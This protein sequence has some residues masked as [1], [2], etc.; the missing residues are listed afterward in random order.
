MDLPEDLRRKELELCRWFAGEMTGDDRWG[1]IR[2]SRSYEDF[3][4]RVDAERMQR[5]R[6]GEAAAVISKRLEVLKA[7]EPV[8]RKTKRHRLH[9][10][11]GFLLRKLHA[12]GLTPVM[13]SRYLMRYHRVEISPRY[14]SSILRELCL[15]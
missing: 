14:L 12:E 8:R 4:F 3:L 2:D 1:H 6:N 9:N 11:Y 10:E 7:N 13:M 5:R 15:K